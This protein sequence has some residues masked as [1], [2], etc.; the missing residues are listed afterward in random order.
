MTLVARSVYHELAKLCD[1]GN[2]E[3]YQAE[4]LDKFS[5]SLAKVVPVTGM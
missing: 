4:I 2:I 3:C 5:E 1:E